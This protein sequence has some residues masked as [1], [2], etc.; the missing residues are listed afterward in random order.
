M[1]PYDHR[2]PDILRPTELADLSDAFGQPSPRASRVKLAVVAV[3]VSALLFGAA[4][5]TPAPTAAAPTAVIA[6]R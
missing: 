5:K 1:N 6:E 2:L 3:A 4:H